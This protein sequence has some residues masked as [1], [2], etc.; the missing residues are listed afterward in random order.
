MVALERFE[1]SRGL[2][3]AT[4]AMPRIR[5]AILDDLRKQDHVPRLAR[6]RGRAIL[7]ARDLLERTLQRQPTEAEVAEQLGIS[8]ETLWDWQGD[9]EQNKR[10]PLERAPV[11]EESTLPSALDFLADD[12]FGDIEELLNRE[13]E[14]EI[15][16][17]AIS[18]LKEQERL[19][20]ALYYFE[21]LKCA[22][23]GKV[24]G[25]TE[26][27][28]SQIRVRAIASL[29]EKLAHLRSYVA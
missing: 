26:S 20:L 7:Q 12:R 8:V 22:E 15:L 14:V 28:V 6:R 5:G 19:V 29:R 1:P 21:D 23:I 4:Y 24:L 16:R 27:R 9:L 10:V 25:V 17:E 11:Q 18:S 3:F 2:S 13:Q